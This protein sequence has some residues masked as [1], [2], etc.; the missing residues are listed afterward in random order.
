VAAAVR[1]EFPL[2]RF[3]VLGDGPLRE[4][5]SRQASSLKLDDC[6]DFLAPRPDPIPYYRTLDMYL[7][8]SLHEGIPLSVIEAMACGT[9]VVS[10]AVGGIPE[11]ITHGEDGFLVEGRAADR[12]ADHC[13]GLIRDAGLRTA[14]GER[15]SARARSHFSAS[16]MA[17]AYR[18][19]YDE[20]AARMW[21]ASTAVS[22]SPHSSLRGR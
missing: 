15:A 22:V 21:G 9:P 7:N 4:A 16:A 5:L 2:V 14:M 12:F 6:L 3:S 11:I 18:D 1:R 17:D 19:L 13:L 10:S 8:T 20:C